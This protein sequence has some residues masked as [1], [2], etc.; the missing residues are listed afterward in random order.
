[1]KNQYAAKLVAAKAALS[2]EA[3]KALVHRCMT[4]IYQAAAIALNEEHGFGPDRITR[5]RDKMEKI[6]IEYGGL[7]EDTDAEYADSNLEEAYLRIMGEYYK[8]EN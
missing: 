5:F 4:T 3:K 7:M 8:K 1:M 2:Q 6:I